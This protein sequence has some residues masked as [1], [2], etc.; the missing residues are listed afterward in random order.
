MSRSSL[1]LWDP[2]LGSHH[3]ANCTLHNSHFGTLHIIS[4]A[5]CCW[6][7]LPLG[8]H[9]G[10][11][12]PAWLSLGSRQG[13]QRHNYNFQHWEAAPSIR[14]LNQPMALKYSAVSA[15]QGL[16]V[17]LP[18]NHLNRSSSSSVLISLVGK[19]EPPIKKKNILYSLCCQWPASDRL[20]TTCRTKP[21][22]QMINSELQV[23]WWYIRSSL[24]LVISWARWYGDQFIFEYFW[25]GISLPRRSARQE[26]ELFLTETFLLCSDGLSR[27]CQ[28]GLEIIIRFTRNGIFHRC[29]V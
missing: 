9:L 12:Q 14:C 23:V 17:K 21:G 13:T 18:Q 20:E 7:N 5:C 1:S 19:N 11:T 28:A 15:G 4:W 2:S 24:R 25:P 29:N 6:W 22:D 27:R 10:H 16:R 3:I 26:L 8:N